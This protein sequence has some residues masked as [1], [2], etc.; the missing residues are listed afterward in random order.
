MGCALQAWTGTRP[1]LSG[2]RRVRALV[3]A[4]NLVAYRTPLALQEIPDP[5]PGPGEVLIDVKACGLCHS[6]VSIINGDYAPLFPAKWPI[7]RRRRRA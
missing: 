6:D 1:E 3:K 2:Y 4:W 5:V 7:G